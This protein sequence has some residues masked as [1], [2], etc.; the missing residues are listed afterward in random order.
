MGR[1][2]AVEG[3]TAAGLTV[4]G[5]HF[6]C[7]STGASLE[8]LSYVERV[9][10]AS[11][12]LN[13]RRMCAICILRSSNAWSLLCSPEPCTVACPGVCPNV[14]L[15]WIVDSALPTNG[16]QACQIA[17]VVGRHRSS[18][19]SRSRKISQE[20]VFAVVMSS[21]CL[22]NRATVASRAFIDV[23]KS[24]RLSSLFDVPSKSS[25]RSSAGLRYSGSGVCGSDNLLARE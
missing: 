10:N 15:P 18:S 7:C 12:V 17:A 2:K 22:V 19:S 20:P 14:S 4:I 8:A 9:R 21:T 6:V 3:L 25:R 16:C 5:R 1:G 11:R 23:V 13:R 24:A